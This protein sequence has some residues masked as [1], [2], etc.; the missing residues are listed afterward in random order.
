[1]KARFDEAANI[2]WAAR[3]EEAGV[4]VTYV[5]VGLKTHSKIILVVRKDDN[6]IK[7]YLHIGTGN[8][9]AGPARLYS[10]LGMLTNDEAM[11][12]D[13]TE[14]FNYWGCFR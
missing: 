14:L 4:H 12:I 9:H 2:R 3:M 5:V 7:R 10:D 6:G 1:M 8:Y 11:G 13:A